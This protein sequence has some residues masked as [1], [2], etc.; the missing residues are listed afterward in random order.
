MLAPEPVSA[1][2]GL[3]ALANATFSTSAG[4]LCD[5]TSGG[6]FGV[7]EAPL[8]SC[9]VAFEQSSFSSAAAAS[10]PAFGILRVVGKT[11]FSHL[12]VPSGAFEIGWVL[13]ASATMEDTLT[14]PEGSFLAITYSFQKGPQATFFLD[15]A[16]QPTFPGPNT[17]DLPFKPGV[18]FVLQEE[19]RINLSGGITLNDHQDQTFSQF[20][21][22]ASFQIVSTQVL[23]G[24]LNPLPGVVITSESGF[25]YNDPVPEPGAAA[26]Q[27]ASLAGLALLRLGRRRSCQLPAA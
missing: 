7:L 26:L 17:F 1:L 5:Q 16:G 20:I 4:T 14:I 25:N 11:E 2:H 8:I 12:S 18:P 23:D 15:G 24:Q 10:A 3:S 13:K 27:G 22:D 19:M 21:D 9:S 6:Y